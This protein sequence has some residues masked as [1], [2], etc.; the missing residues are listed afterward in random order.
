MFTG[1][2]RTKSTERDSLGLKEQIAYLRFLITTTNPSSLHE[3][4]AVKSYRAILERLETELQASAAP[5]AEAP[6]SAAG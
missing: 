2:I 5:M 3:E 6:D 1:D 4:L